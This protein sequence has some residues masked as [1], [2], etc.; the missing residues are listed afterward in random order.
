MDADVGVLALVP[1]PTTFVLRVF[2][3]RD[4]HLEAVEVGAPRV[5]DVPQR[6]E[7]GLGVDGAAATDV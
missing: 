1:V 5:C 3:S 4:D 7:V 6:Q 2:E